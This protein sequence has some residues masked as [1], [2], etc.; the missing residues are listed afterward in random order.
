LEKYQPFLG[1]L[2]TPCEFVEDRY[3]TD[4]QGVQIRLW[5]GPHKGRTGWVMTRDT[6]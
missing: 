5:N 6:H 3:T 4:E 1:P 2:D